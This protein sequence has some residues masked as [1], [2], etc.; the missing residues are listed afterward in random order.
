[1]ICCKN[2]VHIALL[3]NFMLSKLEPRGI[4]YVL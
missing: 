4:N 1:M 3:A 2:V